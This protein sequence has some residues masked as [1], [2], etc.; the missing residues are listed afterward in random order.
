MNSTSRG[1]GL[2]LRLAAAAVL[3]GLGDTVRSA[4]PYLSGGYFF[5]M[6][7]LAFGAYLVVT[8]AY[9]GGRIG[10]YALGFRDGLRGRQVVEETTCHVTDQYR[11]GLHIGRYCATHGADCASTT[12]V[13]AGR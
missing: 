12:V 10:G 4:T 3:L 8:T 13:A 7:L 2:L 11:D 6:L 9:A 1:L 5:A